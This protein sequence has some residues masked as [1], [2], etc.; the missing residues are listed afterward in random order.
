MST[1][2][3]MAE[4]VADAIRDAFGENP[5]AGADV[6]VLVED[7]LT[8]EYEVEEALARTGLMVLVVVDGFERADRSGPLVNGT[9]RFVVSV[10]ENPKL[11]RACPDAPTAQ[12]LAELLMTRLHFHRPD[13]WEFPLLLRGMSR[14][15]EPP[16]I[17]VGL[18]F[19]TPARLPREVAS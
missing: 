13:G 4:T 14:A 5:A 6:A 3:E 1:F 15:D 19:E 8:P 2:R 18:T 12:A 9:T 7:K 16:C 11:V 10:V 17:V